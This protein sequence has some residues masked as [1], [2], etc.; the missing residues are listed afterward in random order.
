VPPYLGLHYLR[1]DVIAG[2]V[3]GTALGLVVPLS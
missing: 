1:S 3:L 2:M